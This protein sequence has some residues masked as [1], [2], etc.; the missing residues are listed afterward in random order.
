MAAASMA[1]IPAGLHREIELSYV[2]VQAGG[3]DAWLLMC[4]LV[5]VG[6]AEKLST[7]V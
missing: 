2:V 4:R 3:G 5:T 1:H 7:A 6:C